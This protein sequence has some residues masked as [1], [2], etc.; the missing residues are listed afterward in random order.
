MA[1]DLSPPKQPKNKNS[2]LDSR[3]KS[4]YFKEIIVKTTID[5]QKLVSGV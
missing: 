5:H 1:Y 2:K 3:V 4:I